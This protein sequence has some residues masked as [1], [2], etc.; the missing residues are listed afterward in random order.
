MDAKFLLS[1][2]MFSLLNCLLCHDVNA[3]ATGTITIKFGQTTEDT[4][5]KAHPTAVKIGFNN[6]LK[7]NIYRETPNSNKEVRKDI[8][9]EDLEIAFV[10][11]DENKDL[12]ALQLKFRNDI[13][14]M[15]RS[16]LPKKYTLLTE[17]TTISGTK[18][19]E[20]FNEGVFIYF[21]T[22]S[23]F[24]GSTLFFIRSDSKEKILQKVPKSLFENENQFLDFVADKC[25]TTLSH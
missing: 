16:V 21:I 1:L 20:L 13:F 25:F 9:P 15:A 19:I 24:S 17:K 7:G 11:F 14:G 22:P 4:Y 23:Y 18:Y 6:I 5:K 8:V 3:T 10:L 12:V 2:F